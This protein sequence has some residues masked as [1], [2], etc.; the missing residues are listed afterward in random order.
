MIELLA[1]AG[2]VESFYAAVNNGAN[3]VYLGLKNF[4]ARKNADNFTEDELVKAI[5]Y[6]KVMGVKVYCAL[7]TLVKQVELKDF[8]SALT[9]AISLGINAII[10]QDIFIG[11][12]IKEKLP[13]VELHLSTQA[14][15]NNVEGAIVAQEY[16]FSRVILARETPISEIKKITKIIETEVFIQGALCTSF[17]GHCYMSG[18]AGG[19]SGNRG[20]CKQ[21]CR[22]TY[23]LNGAKE[24]YSICLADLSV[25]ERINELID[26]GVSSFKIE[27]RMRRA[28]YVSA[29]VRYYRGIIYPHEKVKG[30]FSALKRTYNR[31]NYT[32]GLAFKQDKKFISSKIQG[33]I[34][35]K[36]GT[37]KKVLGNRILVNSNHKAVKGDCFK[38]ISN[39]V[40][41]GSAECVASQESCLIELS[42]KGKVEA[43]NEVY[44]T[45]DV[46]L[47]KELL[48]AVGVR[49]L[50]VEFHATEGEVARAK[51]YADGVMVAESVTEDVLP[52]ATGTPLSETIVKEIFNKVAGFPFAV[53]NFNININGAPFG[54]RSLLNALRRDLYEKAYAKLSEVNPVT[55]G[56]L[57]ITMQSPQKEQKTIAVIAEDFSSFGLEVPKVC[58]F[59]P[60]DYNDDDAFTSFLSYTRNVEKYLYVPS[61]LSTA[62][63]EILKARINGF[64]GIYSENPAGIKLAKN[65]GVKLFIGTDFNLFNGLSASVAREVADRYALSKELTEKELYQTE[66]AESAFVLTRGDI[67][68]MELGYCP[69]GKNCA[70]C[71]AKTI[72]ELCDYAGRKF[73]LRRIKLSR[74]YF[75]VYN[76]A[77]LIYDDFN[78]SLYNFVLSSGK[79][80][81]TRY[82]ASIKEY[83][84]ITSTTSGHLKNKVE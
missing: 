28:E 31:G 1:P 22:R 29:S 40:E 51:A 12:L 35:E 13:N 30:D 10:L 23:S 79:D 42:Y 6:A 5:G 24:N 16:G 47:N 81:I 32:E 66:H 45:T 26:A 72:G 70:Q 33:H 59:A 58:I 43:Y 75:E 7:N 76:C 73:P 27:G 62:D 49:V 84:T 50:D 8:F 60:S 3:A 64:D 11:K 39:D 78:L 46:T 17:S 77:E 37:I 63:I 41:V 54:V 65:L 69:Y 56:A 2:N 83:R 15:I 71:K 67:K 20:L 82:N 38:I 55:C 74:C 14:G 19:N 61:L 25:G 53:D 57:D 68:V 9:K 80:V 18:Y 48:S 52:L 4:S 21:P 34:G 44:I 36:V